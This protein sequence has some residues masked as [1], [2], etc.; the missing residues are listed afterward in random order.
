MLNSKHAFDRL[1]VSFCDRHGKRHEASE[2]LD[3]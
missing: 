2:H 1:S 3:R